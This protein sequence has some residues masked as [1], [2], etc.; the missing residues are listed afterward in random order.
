MRPTRPDHVTLTAAL[1]HGTAEL[2]REAESA[3]FMRGL[4]QGRVSLRGYCTL[5]RNLLPA[6]QALETGL[7]SHATDP[8]LAE[9]PWKDLARSDALRSDLLQLAGE[10]WERLDVAPAARRYAERI[11]ERAS[12]DPRTLAAHAY[13]RYL[14][15]LSG[16]QILCRSAARAFGLDGGIGLA[17]YG[18]P[19][20]AD[21]LAVQLRQALDA[22]PLS[23]AERA[24]LVDEARVAFRFHVALFGELAGATAL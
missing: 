14:G 24:A 6:Y 23:L 13:V 12:V 4:L 1:K 2:H 16:G 15:D 7:A 9:I 17:F 8:A 21:V 5:L 18:F 11:I 22:M 3:A 20:S 19:R 10:Q